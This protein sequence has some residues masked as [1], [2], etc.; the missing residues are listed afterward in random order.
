[1]YTQTLLSILYADS[2]VRSALLPHLHPHI[3]NEQREPWKVER[4]AYIRVMEK[5]PGQIWLKEAKAQ[6]WVGIKEKAGVGVGWKASMLWP[7]EEDLGLK[8]RLAE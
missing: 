5:E 6:R 1:M 8:N 2:R 7:R 4:D 3:G